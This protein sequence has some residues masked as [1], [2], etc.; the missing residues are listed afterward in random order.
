MQT[1]ALY[2]HYTNKYLTVQS[3]QGFADFLSKSQPFAAMFVGKQELLVVL[4]FD[5]RESKTSLA[6][7]TS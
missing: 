1:F 4:V 6:E 3:V 7:R 5:A 2:I